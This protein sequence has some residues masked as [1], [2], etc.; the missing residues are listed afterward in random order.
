MTS[1]GEQLWGP[2][3]DAAVANVGRIAGPLPHDLIA[4]IVAI[5]IEAAAVNAGRGVIA[6][7]VADAI[8]DAGDEVLADE[9]CWRPVP[10]RRVPDRVGHELEHERQRGARP[11]RVRP[12]RTRRASQRPRERIAVVER[13]VPLR[14]PDRRPGASATV[15]G[16]GARRLAHTL[17]AWPAHRQRSSSAARTPHGRGADDVRTEV[18][19]WARAVEQTAPLIAAAGE[20]LHELALGGTAVGTG[21]NAP[22][23]SVPRWP[24]R[25]AA[26]RF[27]ARGDRHFES[28][29]GQEALG[30]L[31][32]ACRT[33]A[34]TLNK[35]AG[36]IRLLGSGPAGGLGEVVV[37]DLQA[38]SSIMPGKV[39]PVIMEVVQQIAAQVVGNDAAITFASTN[40]TL[41]ITTAMP[42]MATNLLA[43]IELCA[44]PRH[45]SP[46]RGSACSRRTRHASAHALRS[47]S[48]VTALAPLIGYDRAAVIAKSMVATGRRSS[49][50][51]ANS[52]TTRGTSSPTRSHRNGWRIRAMRLWRASSRAQRAVVVLYRCFQLSLVLASQSGASRTCS[53]LMLTCTHRRSRRCFHSHQRGSAAWCRRSR[54][55][56][57]PRGGGVRFVTG[58]VDLADPAVGR[59]DRVADHIAAGLDAGAVRPHPTGLH[60]HHAPPHGRAHVATGRFPSCSG[61]ETRADGRRLV[62]HAGVCGRCHSGTTA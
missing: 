18:G 61:T 41:Q 15:A 21:L 32:G 52:A 31:S 9:Q 53:L 40:A 24:P 13:R 33:V 47:P 8:S 38:G 58:A 51:V 5:K 14:D 35:I 10:G 11:L 19:G 34:L 59:L 44:A 12:L 28:Q 26:L 25:S 36:D 29:S 27:R 23:G 20:R 57:P 55:R 4:A 17:A 2:Q 45:C 50:P 54:T 49:G 56:C 22:P 62:T 7:D 6:R 3:T 39:N 43:S 48:L 37:P 1:Q 16:A 46:T 60:R 30:A 42:V